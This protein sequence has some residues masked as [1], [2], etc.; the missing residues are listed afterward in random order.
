[1]NNR[2]PLYI[3]GACIVS[4]VLMFGTTLTIRLRQPRR[5]SFAL[6]PVPR[7]TSATGGALNEDGEE[8][9]GRAGIHPDRL[10]VLR[11]L[12]GE[13]DI[14][15]VTDTTL[16]S[17]LPNSVGVDQALMRRLIAEA[18]IKPAVG[19]EEDPQG[20]I[21]WLLEQRVYPGDAIPADVFA[22]AVDQELQ[23]A[24]S[25]LNTRIGWQEIGPRPLK[26]ITYGGDSDQDTSGRLLS[27]AVHPAD[28]NIVL[29]G[30]AQGGIWRST[31]GGT[32]FAPVPGDNQ[33][34][35]MAIKSLEFAPGDPNIV[36]AGTGDPNGGINIF[37]NDGGLHR[38]TVTGS[39]QN[40]QDY[41]WENL[42]A[43]FSTLQ[44]Y[45]S[46]AHPAGDERD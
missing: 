17:L 27:I 24:P 26:E 9:S 30:A 44:F 14:E 5:E 6:T 2:K 46:Q 43:S 35:S 19:E 34:P 12:A 29:V 42:N 38:A 22:A 32:T 21:R 23:A 37:G 8:E 10:A 7:L 40:S 33:F 18:P 36:Y 28:P 20:R 31:D 4:L 3:V 41:T 15:R 11:A 16:P 39:G 25:L 1:M 45:K 13:S